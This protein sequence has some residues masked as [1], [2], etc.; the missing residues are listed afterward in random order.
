MQILHKF[1][2]QLLKLDLSRTFQVENKSEA[3]KAENFYDSDTKTS[4]NV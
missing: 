4:W 1:L 3:S 2:L